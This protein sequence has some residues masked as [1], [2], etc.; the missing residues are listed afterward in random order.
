[1]QLVYQQNPDIAAGQRIYSWDYGYTKTT[2]T[3]KAENTYEQIAYFGS[4]VTAAEQF[5]ILR[6]LVS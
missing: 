4:R 2:K 6:G 1:M 3:S 5:A